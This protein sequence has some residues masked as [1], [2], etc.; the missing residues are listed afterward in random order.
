M[1]CCARRWPMRCTSRGRWL[2]RWLAACGGSA[3]NDTAG[4]CVGRGR[5]AAASVDVDRR[6]RCP[7]CGARHVDVGEVGGLLLAGAPPRRMRPADASVGGVLQRPLSTFAL[8]LQ[9]AVA[10]RLHPAQGTGLLRWQVATVWSVVTRARPRRST[11]PSA[12]VHRLAPLSTA[13]QSAL[14]T[15]RKIPTG[16]PRRVQGRGRERSM[17]RTALRLARPVRALRGGGPRGGEP[18]PVHVLRPL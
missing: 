8:L 5:A 17:Q 15:A 13:A 18:E 16:E 4:G 1:K 14:A 11:R 10:A 7:R 9:R 3:A 2:G 12:W 6:L